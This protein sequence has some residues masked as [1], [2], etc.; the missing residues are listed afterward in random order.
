LF[1][2][3]AVV[4]CRNYAIPVYVV[5]VPAPFG[6]RNVDIKWIDPDPRFNQE[7]QWAQVAQ[8][9]ETLMPE[10][11]KLY[12]SGVYHN[13]EP[14]DSGFGPFGLTRLAVETGGI[15]FSVHP[16]RKLDRPIRKSETAHL[17]AYIKY[18]F[19]PEIMRRYR[20]DYVSVKEYKRLVRANKAK[21]ALV[22]AA[23][24]SWVAPM[25]EPRL[26]FPKRSEAEL[27]QSLSEAQQQAA[28]ML[29]GTLI[30][31]YQELMRGE[32]GRDKIRRLRWQ[33]GFDLAM[34]RVL[35]VKVRTEGYNS[36]LAR[37]KRGMKFRNEKN[38]TW[39]LKPSVEQFTGSALEKEALKAQS[40]LKR[41]VHEHPQTPWALLASRELDDPMGW[42]WQETFTNVNP[43][44]RPRPRNNKNRP[45]RPRD[46]RR[47]TIPK[48]PK[49]SPPRL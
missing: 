7:P 30:D 35:A 19:D 17:S 24:K 33:A 44:P 18:F 10:R 28:K 39:V 40:Y 14:L 47:Q 9:P 3:R 5:G 16:N 34:G 37:A 27:A 32:S 11:V 25:V 48:K 31:V 15:Y 29:A 26:D 13:E 12:F 1:L 2:D 23:A 20:P 45:P 6:R 46:D 22:N 36:M 42:E 21:T 4:L 8:G 41:V 49:R 38:D 43:P